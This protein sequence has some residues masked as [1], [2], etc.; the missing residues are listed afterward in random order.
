[1]K[2]LH[3]IAILFSF[4]LI[5]LFLSSNSIAQD[6]VWQK[7]FG[8]SEHDG[9]RAI[10]PTND[11]GFLLGGF[12]RSPISGTKT[13]TRQGGYDYWIIKTDSVGTSLWQ[14]AIGGVAGDYLTDMITTNDGGYLLGGY[15]ISKASRDKTEDAI[16]GKDIWMVKVDSIGNILWQNTIGGASDDIL[17]DIKESPDGGYY[18][19]GSSLS[20]ISGDKTMN[21]NGGYDYWIVKIDSLGAVQWDKTIGGSLNDYLR[22]LSFTNDGNLIVGGYSKSN[23]SGDK[24]EDSRGVEDYWILKLDTAANILWQKTLGGNGWDGLNSIL[25]LQDGSF[26]VEGYSESSQSGDKSETNCGNPAA[27]DFWILK[28]DSV[29]NIIWQKTLGGSSIDG[30][31]TI[32]QTDDLG[33]LV[34][35]F[36]LSNI[37]CYKTEPIYA[38]NEYW[39]LKLN[40]NGDIQWQNTFFANGLDYIY[41]IVQ[42]SD[43]DFLIGGDSNSN[44]SPEKNVGCYGVYDIWLLKIKNSRNFILGKNYLDLNHNGTQD[45]LEAPVV[46]NRVQEQNTN[47]IA[48]TN[49][50]G[51]YTVA[52]NDTG[53]YTVITSAFDNFNAIPLNH[54]A[55]FTSLNQIDSLN[56]FG[57]QPKGT[58]NDLCVKITPLGNFRP[59][60][61][62]AY[63]ISY[64]NVGTTVLSPEIILHLDGSLNYLGASVSPTII[65]TDTIVWNIPLLSPL[66][67]GTIVVNINVK[68]TVS[69]GTLIN[70]YVQINPIIGD[71]NPGCNI[72]YWEVFATGSYDPNDILVDKEYILN[73]VVNKPP[74]LEYIIRFQNTGNDT[75]FFVKIL[76][77]IDTTRLDLSTI[78]F[79]SSSHPVSNIEYL[80]HERNLEFRF[81]NIL[82]PDSNVNVIGSNGFVRYNIRVKSNLMVGD[83]IRNYAYIYFDYNNPIQTNVAVTKIELPTDVEQIIEVH[84][85]F[86]IYPNPAQ[87]E[88]NVLLT[89]S[90][91]LPIYIELYD[92]IGKKIFSK[93]S[94]SNKTSIDIKD[95]P[96]GVYIIDIGN[97]KRK[98]IKN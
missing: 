76:N 42:T 16:G 60:F 83:E 54:T 50:N 22:T 36:S 27:S 25:V 89:Y 34:G 24:S 46:F 94:Y 91:K 30:S 45:S 81:D 70:S 52:L 55:S 74:Y 5:S 87:S 26:I 66:Q 9:I 71:V 17:S 14:K 84:S 19:A 15:S 3:V 49:P 95:L 18:L 33:F 59:G 8:G 21:S 73:T 88:I 32:I 20:N 62:T 72:S 92:I 10:E 13:A 58:F 79:V 80:Y 1:M 12:S 67:S 29:G 82:L 56:D 85:N 44:V 6:I 63:L 90:A 57:Y 61:N 53:F 41:N 39:I 7:V 37:S 96:K 64:K 98:F 68:A 38:H 51:S 43:G 35:G 97:T 47:R 77:P 11:K 69:I 40:E 31:R 86:I 75:A 2:Q 78:N 23:I 48:F 65:S 28:L 4:L 93:M